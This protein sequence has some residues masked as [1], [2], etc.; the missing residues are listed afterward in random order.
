MILLNR[1]P[2]AR[3]VLS[4]GVAV[5]VGG[6]AL[7]AW[8]WK[9]EILPDE[10]DASSEEARQADLEQRLQGVAQRIKRKQRVT[11]ELA[12]GRLTLLRAAALFRALAHAPPAFN[13]NRFRTTW[14]GNSDD[15]R[16]CQEVI[17]WVYKTLRVTDRCKA[18]ALRQDLDRQL[19]EHQRQ[20]P[21][22]LDRISELPPWVDD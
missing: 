20:G 9:G 18:E 5:L 16:H 22:R 14:P 12:A 13:W 11:D 3:P 21:L 4:V 17:D 2:G 15:E 1:L 7:L 8:S 10:P 6:L 19:G